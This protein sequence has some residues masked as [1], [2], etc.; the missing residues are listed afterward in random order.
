M[1]RNH[2]F[3]PE[4]K[5]SQDC[6]RMFANYLADY[7]DEFNRT[8]EERNYTWTSGSLNQRSDSTNSSFIT[9]SKYSIVDNKFGI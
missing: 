7:T 8:I 4:V 6:N 3:K 5:E 9:T 1:S 2:V